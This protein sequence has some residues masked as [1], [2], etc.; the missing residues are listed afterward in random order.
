MRW[1]YH[2]KGLG[3]RNYTGPLCSAPPVARWA[4]RA[5]LELPGRAQ[6]FHPAQHP[7]AVCV[8]REVDE[9]TTAYIPNLDKMMSKAPNVSKTVAMRNNRKRGFPRTKDHSAAAKRDCGDVRACA[10]TSHAVI[11]G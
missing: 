10:R 2:S 4:L 6:G 8:Y 7:N 9:P 5:A 1:Y 11:T 3:L